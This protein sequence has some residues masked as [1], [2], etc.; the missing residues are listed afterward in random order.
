[1]NVFIFYTS[2]VVRIPIKI[3]M[4]GCKLL[5]FIY[6]SR[7]VV[8]LHNC[9]VTILSKEIQYNSI[10]SLYPSKDSKIL[11]KITQIS[12]IMLSLL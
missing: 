1:M 2:F 6:L 10:E 4:F 12:T 5:G 11:F 3:E 8:F 7:D 9:N